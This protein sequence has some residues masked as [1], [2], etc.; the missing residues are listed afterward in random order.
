MERKMKAKGLLAGIGVVLAILVCVRQAAAQATPGVFADD[1]HP[2]GAPDPE[3]LDQIWQVDPLTGSVSITIPFTTTPS[4]GR[5]PKIPFSLHYNSA[6]TVTLQPLGSNINFSAAAEF[7]QGAVGL[8]QYIESFV[9]ATGNLNAV[10][11]GSGPV[12]PWTTSGPFFYDNTSLIPTAQYMYVLPSGAIVYSG[13]YQGCTINGPF[14]YTD[15][16]GAAHDM[17]LLTTN[18]SQ[19]T[20][21]FPSPSL[22]QCTT[23]YTQMSSNSSTTD[24][25]ALVTAVTPNASPSINVIHPDGMQVSRTSTGATQE[26]DSNGNMATLG[27]NTTLN[28]YV[29]TDS[30]GR[31]AF[32][33]TLPIGAPGMIPVG[34]YNV[35]TTGATGSSEPYTVNVGTA[36][37]G[38]FTMPHPV[39]GAI[40]PNSTDEI[41]SSQS[42]CLTSVNCPT[43]YGVYQPPY[44]GAYGGSTLSV[45]NSITL[46]DSTQYLFTYDPTYGTISKI[47]FPTGG[48]VRFVWTIRGDGGGY[49][50]FELRSTIVVSE[51]CTS[52]GSGAENCWQYN[53]P[54]Y[55]STTG[56][57]STVTAPDGSTTA[58]TGTA[59]LYSGLSIF[60]QGEA[61]SWKETSRLEYSSS[62]GT[63]MKS[64]ATTYNLS[65]PDTG[66]PYQVATTLYDGPTTT[67]GQQQYVQYAYD[68]YTNVVEKDESDFNTCTGL[69]C[70][71]PTNPSFLRKT[72]TSYAYATSNPAFLTAHIV[73]KPSQVLVTDGSNKAYSL[74]SYSYDSNGNLLN[75]S[76]CI[77]G[78]SV[79][80]STNPWTAS[81]ASSWQTQYSYDGTGQLLQKIEGY[82]TSAH[83][84]T[85]YTWTGPAGQTDSYNGYL[86]KITHPDGTTEQFT[87]WAPIGAIATHTDVNGQTTTYTYEGSLNRIASIVLPPTTDGTFQ[88]AGGTKTSGQTIYTYTDTPEAFSVQEQHLVDSGGTTTSVTKTYDGL[89]RVIQTATAVPTTQC[90][91][92]FIQVQTT[93][94]SMSRVY[95]TS[96]PFCSTSDPTYGLTYFAYDGLGR[97]IQTT[98]PDG[99]VSTIAYI[100]NTTETTDP[101]N[102]T[103]S[104]QHIQQVDG[105]G[106]LTNVCEVGLSSQTG[107]TASACGTYISGFGTPTTYTN[108]Q[109]NG[110]LTTYTYDPL[111]NM[112][113]VNQHGQSRTFNYDA[114]SRLLCASNPENSFA[115]C[116][117][118]NTGVYVTGTDGYAYSSSSNACSPSAGVPCTRTDARGVQTNYLYDSMSRLTSKSYSGSVGGTA[119]SDLTSCYLYG[120]TQSKNTVGRLI[121][122]WQQLQSVSGCS[123][124]PSSAI[125]VRYHSSYDAMGRLLLDQQCLTGSTCSATTGNFVYSYNLLGNPVQSNNGIF[126]S[127][128]GATQTATQNTTS[129]TAPSLTWKTSYDIADHINYVGVQDQPSTSVFPTATYSFAPTLLLPTSYDPFSHLTGAQLGIPN[130]LTTQAIKIARQ[131]DNRGRIVNETDSGEVVTPATPSAGEITLTGVE[132]GPLTATATP[133][134]GVLSVSGSDGV[135]IVCTT[136]CNQY[137]CYQTCNSVPAT[138]T[139]NV[140]VDGLTATASYGSGTTDAAIAAAIASGF[141]ASGSP[142]TVAYTSGSSFLTLTAKATGT[143]SNYPITI[144]NGGGYTISDPNATLTG[145]HNAGT[146][147]DA[148]TATVTISGGSLASSITTAAVSWGQGD[149]TSTV[150]ARLASAINSAAGSIMTATASGGNI[151]LASTA[152]GVGTNYTVSV[153]ITDSMTLNYPTLFPNASFT[154]VSPAMTGGAAAQSGSGTIYSYQIPSGG[155]APNGNI[156]AHSDSVMGNWN[157]TYD[158]VDRLT[159]AAA[160]ASAPT[161]TAFQNQTAAWS[162]DSYGNRTAQTFSNG[163]YSNYANYNPAN[164]RITTATSAVAGY[165]YDASGNTLYDGNHEYWYDAEGQLCA[166]APINA[167]GY[168]IAPYTA[169]IYDAEGARIGKGTLSAA[170]PNSTSLCATPLSSGFTLSARYL[171]D[172]GGDQMTELSEQGMP[173]PATEIWKHS[174]VFSAARLTATY[175]TLGLHYELADPLGTKRVQAN[176]SGQI[177]MSWVS[178]PFGDALTPIA[179]PNPPSTADDA[180]EHHF[181]QKER[182]SESNNDYFFARYYNSAIGRFTT[183]DWSAKVEP[184]PYAAFTDPQSLN[185]YLY[186]GSNPLIHVDADG[187]CWPQWICNFGQAVKNGVTNHGFVTDNTRHKRTEA[188]RQWLEQNGVIGFNYHHGDQP[189]TIIYDWK[190]A[191]EHTVD[192]FYEKATDPE[193][194]IAVTALTTVAALTTPAATKLANSLG[195]RRVNVDW[196]THGQA[197]YEKDGRYI[198]LDKDSHSGGV[199]KE[200]N[201]QGE[202]IGTLDA[203]LNRIGK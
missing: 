177:E 110:S 1:N 8:D 100:G 163:L 172:Q 190:T 171:V 193:T 203:N 124:V 35:T 105:L 158:M 93:Y 7:F 73:N 62:G 175:D 162:Y 198:S 56:L 44:S 61:P 92:G 36:T 83:A 102:G 22:P 150:A 167:Y 185:L 186:A 21:A 18:L 104:V 117:A 79:N 4:G 169:Y 24:G 127:T 126:A 138:G 179:P 197:V 52:T 65:G 140:T 109:A 129:I 101:P 135:Q 155:Y 47:T 19:N 149:T 196:D 82:G 125:A 143:A 86:T 72:F 154:A 28:E 165:V 147:Y 123:A 54:S 96:N 145:G 115:V 37:L 166:V 59:I 119:V 25:S 95:S 43:N 134:S 148:G 53:F 27:F 81:C 91:D 153:V 168:P 39:G 114:L 67:T 84:P 137:T 128:V 9:W 14:I 20:T 164:N 180:T 178:L 108:F 13:A 142:V 106:R 161:P 76:K 51:V 159:T 41:V 10:L 122:E 89:G 116:P 26:E 139:L 63:P 58:Y 17:N 188:R 130:G 46:P 49:G 160:G 103:T 80:T 112:L 2:A 87:Y 173:A 176:I 156:L 66:L 97:K 45:V 57:T 69:P 152:T 157:F 16:S 6:S 64:V 11:P 132:A 183:P 32:S 94:D 68:G 111:G 113:S 98:L 74:V 40:G 38:S 88:S 146:V 121:A 85:G 70:P 12:G 191:N 99:A 181:T 71:M 141:A 195:F 55:S 200:F 133:G 23:A 50:Q 118:T 151:N 120:T 31:Y 184:V 48:Y 29:A 144:S 34:N 15:T 189:A 90:G 199:W 170:P 194:G 136:T 5:G 30:L 202:R 60:T 3:K 201:R 174:N 107:V 187:H 192:N 78:I 42:Y 182:D 131:Y 33:T 77:S 75:E